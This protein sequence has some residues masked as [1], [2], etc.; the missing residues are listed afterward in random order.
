[1]RNG[2]FR[3]ILRR[4]G[5]AELEGRIPRED[6][7]RQARE[8]QP[9]GLVQQVVLGDDDALALA[10]RVLAHHRHA[11]AQQLAGRRVAQ[12]AQGVDADPLGLGPGGAG[13][14]VQLGPDGED[15]GVGRAAGRRPARLERRAERR[16]RLVVDDR[17]P[18]RH[19]LADLD[20]VEGSGHGRATLCERGSST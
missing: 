11:A 8:D 10:D 15:H 18:Q 13:L 7:P 1:M 19:H 3:L 6:A 20:V 5:K 9:A 14:G 2:V 4:R 17:G 16:Q 12:P